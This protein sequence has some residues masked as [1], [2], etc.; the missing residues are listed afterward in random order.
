MG[1]R[2]EIEAIVPALSFHDFDQG[3]PVDVQ[4]YVEACALVQHRDRPDVAVPKGQLSARSVAPPGTADLGNFR[5]P[6][7]GESYLQAE[8]FDQPPGP[9]GWVVPE[10]VA[11]L[12]PT[13]HPG[14]CVY[15]EHFDQAL[16]AVD[17]GEAALLS[18]RLRTMDLLVF[19]YFFLLRGH[20]GGGDRF[21]PAWTGLAVLRDRDSGSPKY[22]AF[23]EANGD[24]G[25]VFEWEEL[26][27]VQQ[28]HPLVIV[29]VNT[30]SLWPVGQIDHVREERSARPADDD[31]GGR[32]NGGLVEYIWD[33]AE[34]EIEDALADGLLAGAA[35]GIIALGPAAPPVLVAAS[36]LCILRWAWGG[37]DGSFAR[38]ATCQNVAQEIAERAVDLGPGQGV[39]TSGPGGDPDEPP[40]A[41]NGDRGQRIDREAPDVGIPDGPR[42]DAPAGGEV[43]RHVYIIDEGGADTD[44][45]WRFAGYWGPVRDGA[46]PHPWT[47][48]RKRENLAR[49]MVLAVNPML[50]AQEA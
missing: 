13:L 44:M 41:G 42:D 25:D 18:E 8:V 45:W 32:Q 26:R 47:D 43:C 6:G 11:Q 14:S 2:E 28:T 40:A 10:R 38:A 16:E 1:R 27:F 36:V 21:H 4:N 15:V 24:I 5:D 3:R 22:A 34:D 49:R 17:R 30:R 29:D 50:R 31:A 23:V 19:N 46:P 12:E 20:L 48:P 39:L 35:A 33:R 9:D 7:H 37:F